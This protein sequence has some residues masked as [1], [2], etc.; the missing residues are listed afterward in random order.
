MPFGF[1]VDDYTA[2]SS[3]NGSIIKLNIKDYLP[4]KILWVAGENGSGTRSTP[5][6]SGVSLE[7]LFSY[8]NDID[9]PDVAWNLSGNSLSIF[10]KAGA[11]DT[12]FA[13]A[14]QRRSIAITA[15]TDFVDIPEDMLALFQ[16]YVI[17]GIQHLKGYNGQQL[18]NSITLEESKFTSI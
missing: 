12:R 14:E 5:V 11:Y 6:T 9:A 4:Y 2:I 13:F 10:F 17:K 1:A 8:L 7:T 15:T 16:L 3:L 18:A